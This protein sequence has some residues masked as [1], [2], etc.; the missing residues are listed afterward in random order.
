VVTCGGGWWTGGVATEVTVVVAVEMVVGVGVGVGV[1]VGAGVGVGV[2]AGVVAGA[3]VA[4]RVVLVVVVVRAGG[5]LECLMPEPN[6][7]P[8]FPLSGAAPRAV[9]SGNAYSLAT[10]LLGST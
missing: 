6:S 5:A 4:P 10:G 8:G 3:V 2:G 1:S 9:A 7:F